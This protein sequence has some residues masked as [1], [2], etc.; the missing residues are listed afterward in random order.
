MRMGSALCSVAEWRLRDYRSNW[1][2]VST[3]GEKLL[4]AQILL[5]GPIPEPAP[6][7]FPAQK[8]SPTVLEACLYMSI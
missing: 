8:N 3:G 1:V 2:V 7:Q 6:T 4:F 5:V